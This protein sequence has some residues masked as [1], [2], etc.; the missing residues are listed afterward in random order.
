[1]HD[2]AIRY[3]EKAVR[4]DPKVVNYHVGLGQT[5]CDT[6]RLDEGI[7]HLQQA[8]RIAPEDAFAHYRLAAQ[9][10]RMGRVDEAIDQFQQALRIEP[11]SALIQGWL[12][13]SSYSAASSA[14]R[15]VA[16]QRWGQLQ[17]GATERADKRRQGWTDCGPASS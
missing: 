10:N 14:I 11:D 7:E 2:E 9:L 1:Q 15:S 4:I 5:L 6:G 13:S 3:Y 12:I 16:E 8:V 17:L